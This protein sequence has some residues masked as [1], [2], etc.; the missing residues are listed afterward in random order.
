MDGVFHWVVIGVLVGIFLYW[1]GVLGLIGIRDGV[2]VA[3]DG[4]FGN[5]DGVSG[6]LITKTMR[7]RIYILWINFTQSSPFRV[8]CGLEKSK[9]I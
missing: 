4:A 3:L 8:L 1:D 7:I 6:I 9:P 2:F 5:W